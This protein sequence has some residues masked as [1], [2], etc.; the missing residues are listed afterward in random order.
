M[1]LTDYIGL[2][3]LFA[4]FVA[5]VTD[6]PVTVPVIYQDLTSVLISLVTRGGGIVRTKRLRV[7]MHLCKEGV[8]LN[9]YKIVYIHTGW[10]IAD[11]FTKAQEKKDFTCFMKQLGVVGK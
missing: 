2:V 1:A 4:E 7:R 5:F 8:D 6:S 3:E 10:M 11:G 9:K